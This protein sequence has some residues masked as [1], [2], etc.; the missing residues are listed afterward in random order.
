MTNPL[1]A[2]DRAPKFVLFGAA[3]LIQ[4]GL[5]ALMVVDRVN[6]LRTGTDVTLQTRPVDPRDLLRGD[7]VTLSYEISRV[8]PGTTIPGGT[9]ESVGPST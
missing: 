4:I 7:Y 3:G 5:V 1:I 2:L 8:P 9:S 6:I